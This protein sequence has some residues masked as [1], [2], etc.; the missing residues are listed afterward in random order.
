MAR[1]QPHGFEQRGD[2]VAA[3]CGFGLRDHDRRCG[4]KLWLGPEAPAEVETRSTHLAIEHDG[5]GFVASDLLEGFA[6]AAGTYN[7]IAGAEEGRLDIARPLRCAGR[8]QNE[9]FG[10][11]P[12][13]FGGHI[14]F[15]DRVD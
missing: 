9:R 6:R 12:R 8:E 5:I 15:V 14:E 4:R 2:P 10:A 11:S 1:A 7:A 3:C 13:S